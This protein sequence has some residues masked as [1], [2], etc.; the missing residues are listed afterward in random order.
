MIEIEK[1]FL[2]KTLPKNI[3]SYK[4]VKI[5]QG[6]LS[7]PPSP[8]RIRQKDNYFELTKKIPLKKGDF[9]SAEEINLPLTQ[10]EFN[11]IWSLVDRSLEKN[12]YFI[13]LVSDLV[14]ELNIYEDDLKGLLQVEVEFTSLDQ[15]NNFCP[16]DW[17]GRDITQE[18]FA[19]NSFLAGKKFSEIKK[20]L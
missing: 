16:P 15:M 8:L 5:K 2:V 12:R 20:F 10:Y 14:A 18:N 9:S 3:S 11:K 4:S 17:F 7:S 6:Y 19:S 13:P 1:T